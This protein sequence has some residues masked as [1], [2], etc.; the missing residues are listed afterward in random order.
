MAEYKGFL[1]NEGF[2]VP[3]QLLRARLG[4]KYNAF[5]SKLVITHR[6]KVGPVQ[7][8]Q[9]YQ[10]GNYEGVVCMYLPRTFMTL[11]MRGGILT[12]IEMRLAPARNINARLHIELFDNQTIIVNHLMTEVF[13]PARIA[14]GTATCILNLRAGMGKSYVAGG[15][16]ARL[17]VRTL[18]IVP[19]CPLAVQGVKDLRTC[20]YDDIA[21]LQPCMVG[22]YGKVAK[23]KDPSTI[24]ANQDVTVI[25]INSAL[26]KPKEFFSDYS[27]II[28]DEVHMYCSGKRRA[29][30]RK[31]TG[32][33]V[34]GMSATTEDR[35]DGFDGVAHKELAFDGIIRAENIPGFE[36][37]ADAEFICEVSA[38]RYNGPPEHTRALRH[39]STGNIFTAYMNKQYIADPYRMMLAVRELRK[40]Y[41]WRGLDGQT[42]RIFVFCE[43]RD[44]LKDIF[45]ELVK[46]FGDD[47]NA[48]ELEETVGEFIGGIKDAQVVK[49][50]ASARIFLTTYGYSGTGIS[51]QDATAILFLTP[52][53]A[54]MK[55]ILP[56]VMRRGSDLTIP[57]CF[58]DI[59]DNKT[60][61][62]YQYGDRA[63]A[64]EFYK[65]N[66]TTSKVSY[67]DII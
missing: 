1:T 67:T 56:R 48:P 60:S 50:K 33:C 47:V 9:L 25:V 58:I 53:R 2:V 66:V 26:L 63:I 64:Y 40:L 8:A 16:I 32:R 39:E 41:D 3:V 12:Q 62:R 65:M 10:I 23:K 19:K 30:F 22:R 29:I 28:M 31:C 17:G 36:Y 51:I 59:I 20:L 52:R 57:R 18:M 11:M 43:E 15:I 24:V 61:A 37:G 38:I 46:S 4:A 45:A 6:P 13:T 42:H 54:N 5:V 35:S 55:Q 44:P 7:R 27:L 21:P 34:L 49:M 14:A